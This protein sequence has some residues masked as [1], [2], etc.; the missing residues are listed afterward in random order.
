[1]SWLLHSDAG[2]LLRIAL[3]VCIF[4]VLAIVDLRKNGK[5]ATRWREYAFLLAAVFVAMVY[6]ILND[7]ITSRI[8]WEYFYYGK[9][10]DKVLGPT[11]PPAAA[12]LHWEAA[13]VGVKATWS[14]GLVFGVALLLANNPRK[15]LPRL[16]NQRLL[17]YLALIAL[18]AAICGLVFGILGYKGWLN[19]LSP[20]FQDM[21]RA[22]IFR[23]R[24]FICT[25]GVH[26][27][28]YLGGFFGTIGAVILVFRRR[29]VQTPSRGSLEFQR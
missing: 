5:A 17:I 16:S 26:L 29:T 8:S 7:Q 27:G 10:L 14:A 13:K 24:R 1:M 9:E 2:L 19:F 25:W 22:D 6:G 3:G 21:T 20:D 15:N 28:G 4:A 23:P 11:T 18:T 12:A